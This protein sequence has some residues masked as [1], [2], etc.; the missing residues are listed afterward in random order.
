MEKKVIEIS[1]ASLWRIL[2]FG[3]FVAALYIG[4]EIVLG[5]FLALVISSGLEV[6]VSFL[7][8]KGLPRTFGVILVFLIGLMALSLVIYT[9]IPFAIVDLNSVLANLGKSASNSWWG[10]IITPEATQSVSEF[11]NRFSQVLFYGDVS[12]FAIFSRA[13]G[14]MVLGVAILVSSFYLSLS[15]DG[16]ERFIKVV[17][18]PDYE[19]A[20]LRIYQRSRKKIGFWFRTQILLSFLVGLLTWAAL[21][22]LGV[23]HAFLIGVLSGIFELVP[24]AG[25]IIAGAIGVLSAF[26]TSPS[27]AFYTLLVFIAIQQLESH[28]LVPLITNKA[29]GLHPVIVIVSILIGA[30]VAGFWGALIAV[31]A[32]AVFQEI[33]EDWSSMKRGKTAVTV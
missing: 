5:V 32:A 31:P 21:F 8:R 15:K 20:A 17:F 7:E 18:P 14:N 22:M 9:V 30:E 13:L 4:R 2:I 6:A 10:S 1:W 33:A 16:V 26:A 23:R 12:P 11:A 24:F 19:A 25:P 28:V 27:L 29:V 3:V